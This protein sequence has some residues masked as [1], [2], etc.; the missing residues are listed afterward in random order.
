MARLI[1]TAEAAQE[2]RVSAAR[3]R[4]LIKEGRLRGKKVGRDWLIRTP[5]RDPRKPEGRPGLRVCEACGKGSRLD[6]RVRQYRSGWF[7]MECLLTRR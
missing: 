4:Q 2:L 3:V 5:L 7:H 6:A 1:T